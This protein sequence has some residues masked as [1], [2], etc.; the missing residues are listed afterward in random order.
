MRRCNLLRV[1][2]AVTAGLVLV[3]APVSA[4]PAVKPQQFV[5][6][7]RVAPALHDQNKWTP[8]ENEAV[9][10]HFARLVDA[11][12]SGRV[13]FAG[14]TNE[15]LDKTFG[16]VVFEAEDESAARQ[17]MESDPAVAAGVMS[18]SLHPYVLALQRKQ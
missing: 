15:A 2:L 6:V 7:L 4:Q 8:R 5:Y 3:H 14:R 17:F 13:I 16:L 12:R 10:R 11:T 18:A 1:I 9:G